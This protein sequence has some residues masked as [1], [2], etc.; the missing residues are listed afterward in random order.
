MKTIKTIKPGN[1][2]LQ[3]KL[4]KETIYHLATL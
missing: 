1:A 3:I 2:N 4:F